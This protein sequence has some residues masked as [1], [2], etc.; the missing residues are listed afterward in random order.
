MQNRKVE[1]R[2]LAGFTLLEML[3][4][5]FIVG[6][7]TSLM[8]PRLGANLDHYEALSQRKELEDQ[9]R[10]LPRRARYVARDVQ[11]PRDLA[12]TDLGDGSPALTLPAGWH[13]EASP[14]VSISSNGA[15]SASKVALTSETDPQ[16]SA[17][18]SVAEISCELSMQ[19]N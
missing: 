16:A 17:T 1:D 19:I 13:F 12:V 3:F 10:Q 2:S 7:L 15:C 6:L 9:F 8:A 18:Y 4:V 11:L 14:P 5:M